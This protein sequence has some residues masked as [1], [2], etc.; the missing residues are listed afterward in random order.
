[1]PAH[2]PEH[3]GPRRAAVSLR[4]AG[5]AELAWWGGHW[6]SVRRRAP[7]GGSQDEVSLAEGPVATAQFVR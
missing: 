4:A 2:G 6:A 7:C 3:V 1:V 5:Q